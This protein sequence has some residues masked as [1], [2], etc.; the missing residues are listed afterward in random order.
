MIYL[1]DRHR[2]MVQDIL[3]KYP[4]TFYVFGSRL[5]GTQKRL[6]DL[7]LCFF[8]NIP[9]NVKSHIAEDFDDSNL[10]FIVDLIDWQA[11]SDSFRKLINKDCVIVQ[12]DDNLSNIEKIRKDDEE[13]N[14]Y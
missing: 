5:K 14:V 9:D 11:W 3:K 4:Y 6:S 13:K 10:P 8:E 7:D 1:E 2:K 12:A